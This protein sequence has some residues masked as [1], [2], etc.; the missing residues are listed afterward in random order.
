M[1]QPVTLA[2][3]RQAVSD[4]AAGAGPDRGWAALLAA[5][6][7]A[8]D[9]AI[10]AHRAALHRWLNAWGCRLRY[11]RPGEPDLFDTGVAAWWGQW[12]PVLPAPGVALGPRGGRGMRGGINDLTQPRQVA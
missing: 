11:P 8:V 5:T 10:A 12:R 3:L 4:F 6:T 7:P 1:T 2:A 9:P